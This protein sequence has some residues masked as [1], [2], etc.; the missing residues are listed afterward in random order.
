MNAAVVAAGAST[1][2]VYTRAPHPQRAQKAQKIPATATLGRTAHL[3]SWRKE[4][5][6][7]G[8]TGFLLTNAKESSVCRITAEA[9]MRCCP[10]RRAAMSTSRSAKTAEDQRY[11]AYPRA[12]PFRSH[13]RQSLKQSEFELLTKEARASRRSFC[14]L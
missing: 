14:Y 6:R 10:K 3:P 12:P 11:R 5:I 13:S 4:R 2:E 7:P 1:P 8:T 9:L